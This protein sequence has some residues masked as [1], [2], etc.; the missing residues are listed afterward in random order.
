[1]TAPKKTPASRR[2]RVLV[3][4]GPNLNLI[5]TREPEIYGAEKLADIEARISAL[6]ASLGLD[7]EFF[8]SNSEGSLVDRIQEAR[9]S[10]DALIINAAAYTHTSVAIRDALIAS[11]VP[12]VEVHLSNIHKREEFRHRSLI[13]DVAVGQILGFGA[14][15]Y[16]LGLRAAAGI[17]DR[18]VS[19]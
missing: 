12:A 15:S 11:E 14:E 19:P 9:G 8:Q 1:M 6:A 10:V 13:A 4:H 18:V 5:G 3:V 17:C 7:V 2:P 16:L